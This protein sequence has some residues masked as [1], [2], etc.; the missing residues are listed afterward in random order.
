VAVAH[1]PQ[2][3][4][5]LSD[6]GVT[7]TVSADELLAHTLAKSLEAPHAGE[8]LLRLV[9]TDGYQLQEL[10]IETSA[11]GQAL[12]QLRQSHADL[13]LGAV[14]KGRVT[15]GITQDPTLS[16]GDKLLVLRPDPPVSGV[17]G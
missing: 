11:I 9:D 4:T 17:T 15:F 2:V 10:P 14:H 8:L 3:A 7:V 5:A 13:V 16:T 6:L 12:S 1:S